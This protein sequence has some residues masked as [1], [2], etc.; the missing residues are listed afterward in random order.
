[1]VLFAEVLGTCSAAVA[2]Q[3]KAIGRMVEQ[4]SLAVIGTVACLVKIAGNLV[5]AAQRQPLQMVSCHWVV[6]VAKMRP[7][8]VARKANVH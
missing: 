8:A 6:Q 1:V 2:A 5:V 3:T 4:M 7:V